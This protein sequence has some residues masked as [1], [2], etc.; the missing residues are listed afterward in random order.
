MFLPHFEKLSFFGEILFCF[1]IE[2]FSASKIPP[3]HASVPPADE[4]DVTSQVDGNFN[5]TASGIA[6]CQSRECVSE[7]I[8]R[9]VAAD[10]FSQRQRVIKEE[11]SLPC[12][13]L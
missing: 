6:Q 10:F 7:E 3:T 2:F 13:R 12:R 8:S 5:T 1:F 4:F 9:G 11:L